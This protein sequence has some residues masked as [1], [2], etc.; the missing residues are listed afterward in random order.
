MKNL[1]PSPC[2]VWVV[3]RVC[4]ANHE[5]TKASVPLRGVGCFHGHVVH[6][7]PCEVSVPL[8]GVGCFSPITDALAL[9]RV[10]VPLRGVGCFRQGA[11]SATG[12]QGFP[13]PCGVWV[14][15]EICAVYR[16]SYRFRPLAG[17]GLFPGSCVYKLTILPKFPSP[18]GVW[19]VS[20]WLAILK[21]RSTKFPSPCG[22]WVVSVEI[23]HSIVDCWVSVPLRGVGCFMKMKKSRLICRSFRPLAGCGLFQTKR[24]TKTMIT[25][26]R[27]LAGCGLFLLPLRSDGAR[28]VSVPLRGVGCFRLYSLYCA[29]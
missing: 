18:C 26:F 28:D 12:Y 25:C 14:V 1:F 6:H 21:Q 2:G 4:Y 29:L 15:S 17:C 27:P 22:V 20:I 23:Y 16:L 9:I 5:N 7:R 10:S 11:A 13:S 24:R 3:S 8:R 19:V